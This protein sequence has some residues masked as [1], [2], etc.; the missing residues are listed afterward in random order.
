MGHIFC[1]EEW[2]AVFESGQVV[3]NW[4]GGWQSVWMH[5]LPKRR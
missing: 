2:E 1:N 3:L 4:R 5:M